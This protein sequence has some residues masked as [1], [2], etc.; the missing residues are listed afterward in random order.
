MKRHGMRRRGLLAA[1][2]AALAPATLGAQ[3]PTPS[4]DE[5]ARRAAI[6]LFPVYEMCRARWQATVDETNPLRQRLNRFRHAERLGEW[7]GAGVPDDDMLS[8]S[9]WLDLSIE[10]LFLT[11]PPLGDLYYCY[12]F[13]DL[14][15]N[16][17]AYVSH[18]LHGGAPPPHMIVGPRWSGDAPSEVTVIRAPTDSVWLLGRLLVQDPEEIERVGILQRRTLLE[19]PDMRNERRILETGELMRHRATAPAEPLADWQLPNADD[20]F[21]LFDTT[22]KALGGSRLRE[23]DRAAFEGLAPLRLKPGRRF[24]RRGFSKADQRRIE[25][26]IRQGLSDI[27]EAGSLFGRTVDGW[28]YPEGHIGNSGGDH[29]YRAH[30]AHTRLGAVAAAEVVCVTCTTDADGRP[31]SGAHRYRLALPADALPPTRTVWTLAAYPMEAGRP[32]SRPVGRLSVGDGAR[33]LQRGE[34]G[35]FTIGLQH[36]PPE[37]GSAANW[38][39]APA[40]AMMLVLRIY[41]PAESLLAGHY[42]LPAIQRNSPA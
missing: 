11:V 42:R 7:R 12:A 33:E 2:A 15:T 37:K 19:T 35:F 36:A 8:S 39:A 1:T 41:A 14:F 25:S 20:P 17:F 26:G 9:A 10:P 30:V 29:L 18:R 4:L 32:G 13:L 24:D 40:G 16:N 5:L 31:L 21:D 34:D 3:P 27:R 22:L 23:R 28:T 6:Y 38:L